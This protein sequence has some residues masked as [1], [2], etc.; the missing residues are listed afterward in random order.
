MSKITKRVLVAGAV[1]AVA[2]LAVV[3]GVFSPS[4]DYRDH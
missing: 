2:F 3:G 1:L 4:D